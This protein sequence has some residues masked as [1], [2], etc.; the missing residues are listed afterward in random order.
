M[1]LADNSD[2]WDDYYISADNNYTFTAICRCSKEKPKWNYYTDTS[3]DVEIDSTNEQYC[4]HGTEPCTL[5]TIL[6][7]ENGLFI[8]LKLVNY[9]VTE[10]TL[11]LCGSTNSNYARGISVVITN[12]TTEKGKRE[13]ERELYRLHGDM[14]I[15]F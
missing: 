14:I 5:G 13:T 4:V 2:N 11:L 9:T 3:S 8:Y 6:V 7:Q 15:I 10:S 12:T 1:R